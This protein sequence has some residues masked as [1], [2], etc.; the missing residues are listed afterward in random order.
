MGIRNTLTGII[1]GT[2]W[3]NHVYLV[4]GCVRDD[5]MGNPIK[6]VDLV[7]DLPDGGIRLAEWLKEKGHSTQDV[8]V[9]PRYGTAMFRLVAFPDDEIEAVQT[10]KEKYPD[11]GSRNPETVFGTLHD[12]CFRRDLT[13]NAMYFNL[14]ENQFIDPTGK[15]VEDLNGHVIRT[16]SDPN[17]VYDDDPLR[18]LRCIRFASRFGWDIDK[19]TWQGMLNNV[20]RLSIITP[21]RMRDELNKMLIVGNQVQA[22][23]LLAESGALYY[24]IPELQETLTMSQNKYHFGTVWQHTMKVL[25]VLSCDDPVLMMAG[26]LHDIGKIVTRSV[27]ADGSVHFIMHEIESQRLAKEIL[28]RLK[29]PNSYIEDVCFLVRNHMHTKFWK[30]DLSMMK[31]KHLRR[32]QYLCGSEHRFGQLLRL[33][34]ADN[35]AHAEAYCLYQQA[36]R[37]QECS[38]AL[39]QNGTAMFRYNPPLTGKDIMA[40]TGLGQGVHIRAF[41]QNLLKLSF[42]NPVRTRKEWEAQVR[43]FYK[44]YSKSLQK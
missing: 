34:D 7:V 10:R 41:L 15:G 4:G 23:N 42:V 28:K 44:S 31:D 18:I 26:L 13:I 5:L 40:I 25:E 3:E 43:S 39:V 8:V 2:P 20:D 1:K 14:S 30:D 36:G 38:E 35:R 12:D 33:I 32:L 17:I 19:E 27:S 16:T 22:M 37:I 9:Y 24:V 6:D 21:E 29:Y 11:T